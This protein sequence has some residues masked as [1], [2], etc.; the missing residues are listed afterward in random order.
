MQDVFLVCLVLG[1][2]V[3]AGQIVLDLFGAGHGPASGD[4]GVAE[5]LE[6][7]SVRSLSAG[8]TLFGAVGFWL[9]ARGLPVPA[10]MAVALLAGGAAS[11]GTAL[12]T[13]QLL[14][15]ESD[16]SLRLENAVGQPGT[17][18]LP[19]PPRREGI[20]RV[21]LMLQGRTVDLR[22][23]CDETAAIPTGAPVIIV[24][25]M[26]DDTVEVMPTPQLEGIES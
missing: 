17:V 5:G 6:L 19:V 20:G 10:S 13:R 11:V 7:L 18:Y 16:G 24:S 8:A 21:Q 26:D 4:I 1:A 2:V 23:V 25:V 22:A 9:T 12:I 15:L 3:L 14:Q